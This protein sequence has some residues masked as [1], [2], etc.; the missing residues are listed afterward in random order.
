MVSG[1]KPG[2]SGSRAVNGIAVDL[3]AFSGTKNT[4]ALK[5]IKLERGNVYAVVMTDARATV[6]QSNVKSA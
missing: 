4:G 6:I 1:V 5:S 3:A 2:E